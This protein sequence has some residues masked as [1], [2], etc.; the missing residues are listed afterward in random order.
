MSAIVRLVVSLALPL[1]V[2]ALSG[3]A[4]ARSVTDWYPALAKPPFNPPSWVFGPVWTALYLMMGAA[5]YLVWRE[6]A[7][8]PEVRTAILLFA[9]QL[10]LNGLW[11]VLF[12]GV[13]SPA[14]AFAEILLLWTAIGATT[15]AFWAIRTT[16]GALLLPYLAW[17]TFAAVLNGSIWW[18]NR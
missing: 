4:T 17:V 14:L 6:G 11:S 1:A 5:L 15:L 16:A 7:Q 12:F 2:G 13:R 10:A 8:R 3:L 9:V 18:L